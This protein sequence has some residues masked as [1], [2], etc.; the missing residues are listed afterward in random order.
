MGTGYHYSMNK[1]SKFTPPSSHHTIR[2]H[3][4]SLRD[5]SSTMSGTFHG[6]QSKISLF[7]SVASSGGSQAQ[8]TP[9]DPSHGRSNGG[10]GSRFSNPTGSPFI[11]TLYPDPGE[12]DGNY[13]TSELLRPSSSQDSRNMSIGSMSG[14]DRPHGSSYGRLDPED[15]HWQRSNE[16]ADSTTNSPSENIEQMLHQTPELRG[17]KV[18]RNGS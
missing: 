11:S 16:A 17:R 15:S 1:E 10:P 3:T 18:I 6:V 8:G 2:S 14:M 13:S 12:M 4:A 5:P 7:P 9:D